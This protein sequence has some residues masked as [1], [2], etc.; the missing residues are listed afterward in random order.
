MLQTFQGLYAASPAM[1]QAAGIQFPTTN[2]SCRKRYWQCSHSAVGREIELEDE[3]DSV[4]KLHCDL[5]DA[6][7]VLCH[8]QPTRGAAPAAV[9]CGR[10]KRWV[11]PGCARR[12]NQH[13]PIVH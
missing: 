5:S 1:A 2:V 12:T 8:M 9:R 3:G 10:G 13:A 4:T 11:L 7:N 6:V